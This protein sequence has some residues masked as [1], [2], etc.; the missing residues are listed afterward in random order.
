MNTK[1]A[2]EPINPTAHERATINA[3]LALAMGW[4]R[5]GEY[6]RAP[7]GQPD[8]DLYPQGRLY[9]YP[10]Y[11]TNAAASRGLVG[12]VRKHSDQVK[13][14]FAQDLC[15]HLWPLSPM[16]T[17]RFPVSVNEFLIL[18]LMAAPLPL[19]AMAVDSAIAGRPAGG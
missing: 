5:D 1:L 14:A 4:T 2:T 8:H 3:R 6:Y 15:L 11:F 12:W 9:G 16:L 17:E 18:E 19:I 7:E 10:D 13:L